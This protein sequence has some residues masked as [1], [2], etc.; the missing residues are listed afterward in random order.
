MR[1][2]LTF[3]LEQLYSSIGQG[4]FIRYL[5]AEI[6]GAEAAR[7]LKVSTDNFYRLVDVIFCA[8]LDPNNPAATLVEVPLVAPAKEMIPRLRCQE[9]STLSREKYLA[10]AQLAES[11]VWSVRVRRSYLMCRG[12]ASHNVRNRNSL[13]LAE[14]VEPVLPS[15]PK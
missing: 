13:L 11:V 5:R 7:E 14:W 4:V 2:Q 1:F 15:P 10:C 3:D 8:A 12:C 9:A 6:S